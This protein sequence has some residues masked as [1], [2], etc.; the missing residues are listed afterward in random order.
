MTDLENLQEELAELR[1]VND[2]DED[3]VTTSDLFSITSFGIDYPVETLVHRMNREQFYIPGFQRQFVWSQ[4]QASRF[5]E[6]LLLGLPVPGIFLFRESGT[7]KHLVIDGQ[8][9]LKSLQFFFNGRFM[10]NNNKFELHGIG[11]D[12]DGKS[13]DRL[14]DED[15]MRLGDAVIHATVF[16]QDSPVGEMNSIYEVFER[17][18]TGGVKLSPQEIRSCICH[19]NFNDF[20]HK[21]NEDDAWRAIY[22]SRSK[23]LKD[24]EAILRFLA[25]VERG[26]QYSSPMKHFL[27]DYMQEKRANTDAELEPLRKIFSDTMKFSIASL[28]DRPFRPDRALNVA[29]FDSVATSIAKMLQSDRVL[30]REET[31]KAYVGL[32]HNEEFIAGYSRATADAENVR[33]RFGQAESAFGVI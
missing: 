15:Q 29:V 5:I 19:G 13:Y 4:N 14:S 6:S 12:W 2:E 11:S 1:N 24:I 8:Q 22:G 21:L 26:H 30:S 17:I 20:L 23:R 25:F 28:G 3:V 31:A 27:N 32:L 18:N 33:K 9:R 7:G 16:K 10:N